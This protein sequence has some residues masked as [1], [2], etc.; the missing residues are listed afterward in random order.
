M[1]IWATD[2][3]CAG[4]D[5]WRCSTPPYSARSVMTFEPILVLYC[6]C[7]IGQH[8]GMG[9]V[10]RAGYLTDVSDEEWAFVL[11]YLLLSRVDNASREHDLRAVFNAVRYVVKDGNQWRLMPNDL[12]PWPA[13]YQQMQRWMRAGC[14]EKIVAACSR[15]CDSSA[16]ARASR[17][18]FVLIAERCSR[19]PSLEPGPATTE[20]SVARDQRSTSR[21]TR[22]AT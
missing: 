16:D 22:W 15:S 7:V 1:Q 2:R 3:R 21:S 14:F 20:P 11:P 4:A 6:A 19:R 9:K 13:A 5:F 18:W 12:P 10:V 8:G 17:L